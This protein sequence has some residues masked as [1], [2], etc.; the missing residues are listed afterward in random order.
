MSKFL[1]ILQKLFENHG[2]AIHAVTVIIVCL[3][4]TWVLRILHKRIRPS[5][6]KTRPVWDNAL[7]EASYMPATILVWVYG[8]SFILEEIFA[9]VGVQSTRDLNTM[10]ILVFLIFVLWF[11]LRF[12]TL[13]SRNIILKITRGERKGD[14]T[15]VTA[16]AQII[17]VTLIV[18]VIL[19]GMQTLGIPI[20]AL[21]AFGGIGSLAVGFAAKDTLSNFL[22]GIMVFFDRPFSVGDWINSP[23]R[24]IEGTVDR[25]GWRL[26]RI[27]SFDKRPIYV[28]NGVFSSIVVRNPSRMTNRRIKATIGLR[29][30]DAS[31]MAAITSAVEEM[32]KNHEQID[33][34]KTLMVF[35]SAFADSSLNFEI[36]TFTKTTDWVKFQ[37]IQQ[38]VFLK[39][40]EIVHQHGAD[41][42]FPTRTLDFPGSVRIQ[43]SPN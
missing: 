16:V 22:G 18:I 14:N 2:W 6:E 39:I 28:P 25:V 30:Q 10:R 33:T 32:L 38:D 34:T 13:V 29:Y 24:D 43:Q 41:F 8:L 31:K 40:I 1:A 3:I 20:S 27:M 11:S 37:M 5:L 36:Y 17:R 35:M 26:T 7:L 21:L 12:I 23:D 15:T 4:L 19:I 9:V 42:A